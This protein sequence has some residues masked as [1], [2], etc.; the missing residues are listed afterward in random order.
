MRWSRIKSSAFF[1]FLVMV[2]VLIINTKGG[3]ATSSANIYQAT[4][5]FSPLTA[6]TS[7]T[8]LPGVLV[9]T[10]AQGSPLYSLNGGGSWQPVHT[11]PWGNSAISM[12]IVPR[13]VVTAPVRLLVAA[14]TS[15]MSSDPSL[16][17]VYR[18]TSFGQTWTKLTFPCAQSD[19]A[20]GLDLV[21]S[22]ADPNRLYLHRVCWENLDDGWYSQYSV[23]TSGDGGINWD[24][25]LGPSHNGYGAMVPSPIVGSRVYRPDSTYPYGTWQSDDG[26]HIWVHKDFNIW[27]WLVLDTQDPNRFYEIGY[28]G[29][30]RSVD[31]GNTWSNW[32]K[33]PCPDS[34][35]NQQL[36]AHPTLTNVLF[37]R[38]ETGLYRSDDGGDHWTQLSAWSGN[39]LGPNYGNRGQVLWARQDGLFGIKDKGSTW[40]KISDVYAS[41]IWPWV[42]I[43]TPDWLAGSQIMA[44][45]PRSATN[46]WAVGTKGTILHWK[47]Y[48][49]TRVASSVETNL[50]SVAFASSGPGWAV[51]DKAILKWDGSAWTKVLTPTQLLYAVDAVSADDAWAVGNQG[52]ILHWD[53]AQ[54]TAAMST[55]TTVST[56]LVE[57]DMVSSTE[58]WAVGAD[59]VPNPARLDLYDPVL[60]HWNG[61][62]WSRVDVPY[63]GKWLVLM[64]IDMVSATDGWIVGFGEGFVSK[65]LRWNGQTWQDFSYD[66]PGGSCSISMASA[67]KGW[68]GTMGGN[69]FYWDG[70]VW[71]EEDL[72]TANLNMGKC[73][74]PVAALPS[75]AVWTGSGGGRI[76]YQMPFHYFLSRIQK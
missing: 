54:W 44:L 3:L 8:T 24:L 5:F 26:G 34:Y 57:L 76:F 37:L 70:N 49:W 23:F 6:V 67:N 25:I 33:R 66:L 15:G 4:T 19:W 13:S 74:A 73:N 45:A 50:Y 2:L 48:E 20:N 68:I 30:R 11:A 75:G 38:C 62:N 59:L 41:S 17:G 46:V 43:S 69:L 10:V 47:N 29:T 22:P 36:V 28:G 21:A 1:C 56:T 9:A 14:S 35:E 71:T 52:A 58:G 61:A 31:G 39:W 18:T 65:T 16:F 32:N 42:N 51:G 64:G 7:S 55:T 72:P 40:T 27:G 60:L 63:Q 53:G 12:A